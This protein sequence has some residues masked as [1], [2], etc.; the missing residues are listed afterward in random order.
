MTE[1]LMP[2]IGQTVDELT[3]VELKVKVGDAVKLGDVLFEVETDKAQLPVESYAAGTVLQIFHAE[4][5]IV[6]VGQPCMVIGKQNE[7]STATSEAPKATELVAVEPAVKPQKTADTPKTPTETHDTILASPKARKLLR[8]EAIPLVS[9]RGEFGD[10]IVKY[11]D[12]VKVIEKRKS[13]QNAIAVSYIELQ[14]EV[15][16]AALHSYLE[17][18]NKFY[19]TAVAIGD[20]IAY[21]CCRAAIKVPELLPESFNADIGGRIITGVNDMSLLM[22]AAAQSSDADTVWIEITDL[23]ATAVTVCAKPPKQNCA[24]SLTLGRAKADGT[25]VLSLVS[26]CGDIASLAS[27]LTLATLYT[28]EP[29]LTLA[30]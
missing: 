27:L 29:E 17:R 16:I 5:D 24:L 21:A 19:G 26:A 20:Y 30:Q 4:G 2:R 22:V 12:A 23:S 1:I 7:S 28:E 9:L 10:K 14:A 3:I 13:L 8:D 25:A 15:K 6:K 11:A 18:L